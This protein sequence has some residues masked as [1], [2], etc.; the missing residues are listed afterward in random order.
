MSTRDRP[1][2]PYTSGPPVPQRRRALMRRSLR[3]LLLLIAAA[4]LVFAAWVGW[5][6]MAHGL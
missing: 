2:L 5:A 1:I 4:A 3:Q 6:M